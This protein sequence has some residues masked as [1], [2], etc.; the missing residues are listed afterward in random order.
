[1]EQEMAIGKHGKAIDWNNFNRPKSI[2]T[3]KTFKKTQG[4]KEESRIP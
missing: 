3:S 1:M 2:P 4:A